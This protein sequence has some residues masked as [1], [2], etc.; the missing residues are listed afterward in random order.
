MQVP[1]EICL[2]SMPISEI[3]DHMKTEHLEEHLRIVK[4]QRENAPKVIC[5]YC[6]KEFFSQKFLKMHIERIHL[7]LR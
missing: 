5:D 1:C 6:K 2:K 3:K 4:D 7:N